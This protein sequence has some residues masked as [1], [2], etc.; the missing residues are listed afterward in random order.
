[1]KKRII[2]AKDVEIINILQLNANV[3][4]K[5]LS[6]KVG[7][8]PGPPLTRVQHLFERKVFLGYRAVIDYVFFGY[9]MTSYGEV[10]ILTENLNHLI[11]MLIS[12]KYV[13]NPSILRP[14]ET[15]N[16]RIQTVNFQVLSKSDQQLKEIL[17]SVR[18]I[19]DIISY[20][21]Y[22]SEIIPDKAH[23]VLTDEDVM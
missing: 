6:E 13:L 14:Y 5:D 17:D 4:N 18:S 12:I 7:K 9:T 19:P 22:K 3:T 1:M 8:T 16:E 21:F 10:S 2:D 15:T 20:K 11:K 23:L